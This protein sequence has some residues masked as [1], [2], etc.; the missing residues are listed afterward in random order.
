MA[1]P[2]RA[3]FLGEFAN[4]GGH[5]EVEA[6][7]TN[8]FGI[9]PGNSGPFQGQFY[10]D[11]TNGIYWIYTGT[12]WEPLMTAGGAPLIDSYREP[13]LI[14][15]I[16]PDILVVNQFGFDDG[17]G[18]TGDNGIPVEVVC[19]RQIDFAGGEELILKIQNDAA[20]TV[21]DLQAVQTAQAASGDYHTHTVYWDYEPPAGILTP[22]SGDLGFDIMAKMVVVDALG[23]ELDCL[24]VRITT[25]APL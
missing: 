7:I 19:A 3:H 15:F 13:G 21:S 22:N 10:K 12:V 20:P 2:A 6:F 4:S 14:C 18:T 17:Q 9:P 25:G 8:D 1:E 24:S 5:V 11:T 23:L 16:Q